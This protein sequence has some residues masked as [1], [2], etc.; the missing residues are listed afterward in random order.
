MTLNLSNSFQSTAGVTVGVAFSKSSVKVAAGG[1]ASITVKLS[2][3]KAA[4]A[5][6]PGADVS[7]PGDLTT[8][9][10]ASSH[11]HDG[12]RRALPT[13]DPVRHGSTWHR[14]HQSNSTTLEF[15]TS[16]SKNVSL[17]NSGGHGGTADFYA[18]GNWSPNAGLGANDLRANGVQA[19]PG[20]VLDGGGGDRSLVFAINTYNA[21]SNASKY[22]FDVAIDTDFD[23]VPDAYILGLDFGRTFTGVYDGRYAS[24]VTDKDF[25][26]I[27]ANS[28]MPDEWLDDAPVRPGVRIGRQLRVTWVPVPGHLVQPLDRGHGPRHDWATFSADAQPVETGDSARRPRCDRE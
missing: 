17:K 4:V 28:R 27:S 19:L 20:S 18:L 13:A 15:G 25:N 3:T 23:T 11:T 5:G 14:R 22:E 1:S 10:G 7:A 6:L 2:L 24:V 9:S 8:I 26:I 16:L 12:R 21:W